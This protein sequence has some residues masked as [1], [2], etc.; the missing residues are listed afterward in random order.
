M[1]V[2]VA[3]PAVGVTVALGLG[4]A[5]SGI[6][7]IGSGVGLGVNGP[8]R[9]CETATP[10]QCMEGQARAKEAKYMT[11]WSPNGYTAGVHVNCLSAHAGRTGST[12]DGV[13]QAPGRPC[14]IGTFKSV[15]PNGV[16]RYM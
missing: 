2:A 5:V 6:C 9:E 11:K 8:R 4:V 14:I 1:D 15:A 10:M 3:R 13:L 12:S 16:D 7:V